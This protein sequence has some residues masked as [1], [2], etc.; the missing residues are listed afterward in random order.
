MLFTSPLAA[1]AA[2]ISVASA[3]PVLDSRDVLDCTVVLKFDPSN[4]PLS[5]PL[6][7]AGKLI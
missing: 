7:Q 5:S 6:V 2:L 4:Y 3:V 1:L